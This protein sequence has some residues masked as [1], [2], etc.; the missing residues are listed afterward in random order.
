M[1]TGFDTLIDEVNR[2]LKDNRIYLTALNGVF[3]EQR[4]RI[5]QQGRSSDNSKIGEYSTKPT[6][7]SRT[8]QTK[9]VGKTKFEGGYREYKT[10]LGKGGDIGVNLRETD[11]MLF[12]LG[13]TVIGKNEFGIGFDNQFNADKKE[14]MEKKYGKDIFATTP[15]EDELFMTILNNEINRD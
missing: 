10:L 7:I 9:F 14:W 4:R 1:A 8:K 13:P 2:K 15:E 6:Y 12:D 11:Q 5:F 3:V